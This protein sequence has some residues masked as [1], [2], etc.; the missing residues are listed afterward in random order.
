VLLLPVVVPAGELFDPPVDPVLFAPTV[1][2]SALNESRVIVA[3]P[4][5]IAANGA[6]ESSLRKMPT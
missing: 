4:L 5:L 3:G 6:G 2:G 1:P